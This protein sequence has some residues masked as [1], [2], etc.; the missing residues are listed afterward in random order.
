MCRFPPPAP[1]AERRVHERKD[2]FAQVELEF[3]DAVVVAAVDNVSLG[4]A[5]LAHPDED[6]AIGEIVRVHLAAGAVETVQ[7]AKVVR[8]SR[9]AHAGFAVSWIAP[10]SR[11]YAVIERLMRPLPVPTPE[12]A[13]AAKPEPKPKSKRKGRGRRSPV[14]QIPA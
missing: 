14:K 10:T 11:T 13:P 12:P 7:E 2:V 4:G 6:V 1:G 5:F 8:V 9:G 3:G